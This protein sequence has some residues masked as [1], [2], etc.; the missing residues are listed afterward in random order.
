MPAPEYPDQLLAAVRET[1]FTF[2]R[3]L[4][5]A[6]SEVVHDLERKESREDPAFVVGDT[7]PERVGDAN[8]SRSVRIE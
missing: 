7:G 3:K 8:V 2:C 5:V 4:S 1:T 6:E